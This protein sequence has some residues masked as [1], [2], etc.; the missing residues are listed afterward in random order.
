MPELFGARFS[1]A[2]LRRLTGTL[3]Q[4]AGI[5]SA[6]LADGKTRGMR[7]ADVYTGSG[8]RFQVLI[9]RALDIGA[10]EFAG[11]PLAWLHPALGSAAQYE[12]QSFGWLRTFGGGL[13]TTEEAALCPHGITGQPLSYV[14]RCDRSGNQK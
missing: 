8:L 14:R 9:D 11:K 10:A 7:V 3:G 12:P 6:E 4:I 2:E 1:A 13:L 5:R